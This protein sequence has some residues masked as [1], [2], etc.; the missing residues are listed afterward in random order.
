MEKDGREPVS[1][2]LAFGHLAVLSAFALAQPLFNLLSDNPEFF[3]ARGSTASEIIVFGVL[4]VLVPPAILLAIELLAGLVS[5]PARHVVHLVFIAGLAAVVFVQAL[6]KSIDAGDA[7]LIVLALALGAAGAVL[8]HRAEPVRSF[9]SVL[10][11]APILFLVLFLFFSDVS[12]IVLPEDAS[13]KSA[14]GVARVPVVVVVLDEVPS[15]SLLDERGA[16][17]ARRYPAFARLAKDATFFKNAHSVYDSTSRAV[18]AIMDG[19]KPILDRRL[20]TASEHPNSIF[21][22]LGESHTMNVSEEATSVCPRDL[23]EDARLDEP[24]VDRLRSMTEDLGRVYAHVV[25]PPGIENDLPTVSESWGDFGGGGGGGGAAAAPANAD[26][27]DTRANLASDR[28]GRFDQWVSKIPAKRATL[29]FKHAL[30]PHVPWQYLPDGRQYRRTAAEP[31]PQISRQSY[32]DQGQVDQLQL[33]HLLQ[34][35]FADRELGKML[36]RLEERGLYDDA[37]VVVV[38]DHGVSFKKGQ[39]DRRDVNRGNIDEI[40]PVPLFVKRPNQARGAVNR[41]IV[42]TTDV[43][44]TIADVLG[45]KLPEKVDGRSAFSDEVK[46][47]TRVSMLKRNLKGSITLSL[48]EFERERDEELAKKVRLFGTGADDPDRIYRIGPNQ[49]LVGKQ[50]T[51]A[52]RSSARASLADGGELSKVNTKSF[53]I[54]NWITGRVSGGSNK[55]IAIAV[56][57]TIEATGNTFKLATGGGEIFG[58]MVPPSSLKNGKNEV[59]VYEVAGGRLLAMN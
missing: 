25:A 40:T 22:L 44:P 13:A 43:L 41:S 6:K 17:D 27:P 20:P 18:P 5:E 42:Q 49:G 30:L 15:T 26:Q 46:R 24:F 29:N 10:S 59:K 31:I 2:L 45:A 21:T 39:F 51:S 32:K 48:D 34:T 9:L 36:E 50:A 55:Q 11:P 38:A 57:G 54:P 37:L 4:L 33:R 56:N 47:R 23:C 8:Y 12:K 35:G 16:I 28:K 7:V 1:A 52:G 58:L 14:E 19:N 3:A 53:L